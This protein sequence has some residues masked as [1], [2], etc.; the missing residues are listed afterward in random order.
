M[1]VFLKSDCV[2]FLRAF[3]LHSYN[4]LRTGELDK[5]RSLLSGLLILQSPQHSAEFSQRHN[6]FSSIVQ[7]DK[8]T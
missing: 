7:S 4:L 1:K 6:T 3:V 5:C 2:W 8:E